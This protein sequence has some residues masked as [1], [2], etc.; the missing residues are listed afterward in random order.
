MAKTNDTKEPG[1]RPTIIDVAREA[2]VSKSL[3]SLVLQGEPSVSEV[4]RK[5]VEKA[6]KKLNYRPNFAARHLASQ[7]TRSI[8]VIIT[9]YRNLSYVN[10]IEGLRAI[11]DA[12]GYQV[13]ISDLHHS[14]KLA[15]DPVD[16]F[17][18]MNVDA[19]V[20]IAEAA[21]LHTT[22]LDVPSV[23]VGFRETR[24]SGTDL[25]FSDDAVGTRMLVR[26]L[27]ELGHRK[28]AH[29]TGLG[30]I[31]KNRRDAFVREMTKL[32]L[33]A[34]VFGTEQPTSEIGGFN[35]AKE[36]LASGNHFTA[37]FAAND[38]MAA[39][40]IS[41]LAEA[42]LRVPEDISIVGYDN[43]PIAGDYL[44]KLTT[45]DDMGVEIGEAVATQILKRLDEP[46]AASGKSAKI[47]LQ[48]TMVVRGSTS[49][50]K[51]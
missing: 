24:V 49:Q 25:V 13:I 43:A 44:L 7:R 31:A 40:A 4:R 29:L 50:L 46:A 15:K 38:Y 30:G 39:G 6:I 5:A 47:L 26:H 21:G 27:Y 3:V 10:V 14:P 2:G 32:R 35:G 45:I 9:E 8:G 37:I 41:A 11:F 22:D 34:D 36:M 16:A 48:P 42:G 19:L 18:S 23:T 12:A 1:S 51:S 17:R 28:I 33:R 20:F